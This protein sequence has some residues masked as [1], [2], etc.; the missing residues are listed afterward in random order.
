METKD[1]N[2]LMNKRMWSRVI[3]LIIGPSILV[4]VLISSLIG[5]IGDDTSFNK[6]WIALACWILWAI[7]DTIFIDLPLS[8]KIENLKK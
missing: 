2:K 3:T 8:K 6:V 5:R 1:L 7:V 4:I